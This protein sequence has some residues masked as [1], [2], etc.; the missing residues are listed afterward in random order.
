MDRLANYRRV[1]KDILAK[2]TQITYGHGNIE[3][4]AISD[5]ERDSYLLLSIGWDKTRRIHTIVFHLR[6][7]ND[8]IWVE[9]DWTANG[10]ANELMDAGIRKDEIVLGFH[11]AEKRPLTEFA[12]A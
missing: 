12:V 6:I 3:R 2:H 1:I 11:S 7:H 5:D 8:K 4:I 9:D 10:I